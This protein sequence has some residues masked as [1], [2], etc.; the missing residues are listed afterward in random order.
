MPL[1]H[2][3]YKSLKDQ[4]YGI[5][6]PGGDDSKFFDPFIMILIALNIIA[7]ILESVTWIYIPYIHFFIIFN[8]FSLIVFSIEYILRLWAITSNVNFSKPLS[9][10]IRYIFTPM[11]SVD[12]LAVLPFYLPLL[13]PEL[14]MLRVIR[15]FRVFRV[16]KLARYSESLQ[17]FKHV[18]F[19]EKDHLGFLFFCIVLLLTLSSCLMFEAE[20]EAQPKVFTSVPAA[21]WWGIV[22]LTTVGYGD[23]Y[24]IT[25]WGKLIGT[26]TV[27][28]GICLFALLT[29]ILAS[30]FMEVAH[31]SDKTLCP[32]CGE[33]I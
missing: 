27:L 9:G 26:C 29:G 3:S 14:R 31:E 21:M 6:E 1:N 5:L 33:K 15:L 19:R 25:P 4:V 11:A 32:H 17:T 28:I 8:T 7:V 20:H 22:T 30:G 12:L 23:M 24:P 16:L 10:R 2:M 13:F 18:I